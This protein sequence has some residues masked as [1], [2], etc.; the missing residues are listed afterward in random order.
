MPRASASPA[1]SKRR[2]LRL[3]SR[4]PARR[5]DHRSC[6][7]NALSRAE[8]LAHR[9]G[10]RLTS[11][12]RRV[13]AMIWARHEPALAYD[14]LERLRKTHPRAAPPTVYRALDFLLREGFVHRIESLNAYVGCGNPGSPH[15]GQF[16][17]CTRCRRIA[18]MDDPG[19]DALLRRKAGHCKFHI[20]ALTV[21]LKGLCP[22]CGD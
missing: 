12:R 9:R 19:I 20:T 1:R 5:H 14:L 16:L 3:V 2:A 6:V 21:E 7:R 8:E 22:A 13:L 18:E 4:F 10:V 17:I 11:I 15:P